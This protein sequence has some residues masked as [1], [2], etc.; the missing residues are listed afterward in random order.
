[1]YNRKSDALIPK[2]GDEINEE[3]VGNASDVGNPSDE[4][5][6][7]ED[8]SD[9]D[10]SIEEDTSVAKHKDTGDNESSTHDQ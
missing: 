10:M 3:D 4:D 2:M 6:T 1:M 5:M 7:D 9:E 8:V